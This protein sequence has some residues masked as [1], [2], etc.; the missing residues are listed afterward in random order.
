MARPAPMRTGFCFSAR[1]LSAFRLG[2]RPLSQ[3][4]RVKAG[5]SSPHPPEAAFLH[6]QRLSNYRLVQTACHRRRCSAGSS[7]RRCAHPRPTRR[8]S[9]ARPLGSGTSATLAARSASKTKAL[10]ATHTHNRTRNQTNGHRIRPEVELRQRASR[11]R[12]TLADDGR[13]VVLRLS[14]AAQR[15]SSAYPAGT[16]TLHASERRRRKR[17]PS[18]HGIPHHGIPPRTQNRS[19]PTRYRA[20]RRLAML[21]TDRR[22]VIGVIGT[23]GDKGIGVT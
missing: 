9:S 7:L 12:H 1:V 4:A 21:G 19:Q 13:R 8:R 16:G 11:A 18:R 20:V 22:G 10:H 14:C 6:T 3:P 5:A 2:G 17:Y 23:H 15:T